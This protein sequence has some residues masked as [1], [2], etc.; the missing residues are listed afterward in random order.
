MLVA[1]NEELTVLTATENGYGKTHRSANT[2][3]NRGTQGRSQLLLA[4]AMV[5]L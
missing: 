1:E 2:R 5:K 4:H 3:H